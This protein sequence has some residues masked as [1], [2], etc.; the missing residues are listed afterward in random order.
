MLGV[1]FFKQKTAYEIKDSIHYVDSAINML[2]AS[3]NPVWI[4]PTPHTD[5]SLIRHDL[6]RL[7]ERMESSIMP[8]DDPEYYHATYEDVRLA[9]N[10]IGIQL[11]GIM[12]YAWL[13]PYELLALLIILPFTIAFLVRR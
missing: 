7:R 10:N 13:G 5:L 12:P 3:G 1:F 4:L 6:I 2:P 8:E 9:L 11:R